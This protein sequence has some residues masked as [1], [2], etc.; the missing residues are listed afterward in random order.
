[1]SP[2]KTATDFCT[3]YSK[4]HVFCTAYSK[5]HSKKQAEKSRLKKG[6]EHC[7]KKGGEKSLF[8]NLSCCCLET[9]LKPVLFSLRFKRT[10]NYMDLLQVKKLLWKSAD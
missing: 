5:K 9:G 3:A 8:L 1:L 6:S 2:L 4:Q 10:Q 7:G